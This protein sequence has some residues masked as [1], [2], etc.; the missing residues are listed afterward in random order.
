MTTH[1]WLPS[2]PTD[3]MVNAAFHIWKHK[4]H[5]SILSAIRAMLKAA[6]QAAPAGEPL[7]E[8]D[9]L[10]DIWEEM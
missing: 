4:A 8:V 3:E 10:M 1:K 5:P 2:E 9:E 7:S 6:W